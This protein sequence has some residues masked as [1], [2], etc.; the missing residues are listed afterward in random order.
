[1]KVL[2]F[3]ASLVITLGL[4]LIFS[5]LL[6]GLSYQN[7]AALFSTPIWFG[8]ASFLAF[9]VPW[10][11][12]YYYYQIKNSL[13]S[14]STSDQWQFYLAGSIV[15]SLAIQVAFLT[16]GLGSVNYFFQEFG[17][18]LYLVWLSVVINILMFLGNARYLRKDTNADN[19][20]NWLE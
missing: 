2:S 10:S 3:S 7:H 6:G 13:D 19:I 20:P 14:A 9:L 15:F 16:S 18:L 11:S 4:N 12:C 5:Y 8:G 1:M 17:V